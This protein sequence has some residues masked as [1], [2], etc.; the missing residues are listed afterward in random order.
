MLVGSSEKPVS[1]RATI[2]NEDGSTEEKLH[3]SFPKCY[4]LLDESRGQP[5]EV[6]LFCSIE[7]ALLNYE[8]ITPS[9]NVIQNVIQHVIQNAI[10]DVI[11]HVIQNVIQNVLKG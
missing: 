8:C 9:A 4:S 10:Q 2:Q 7:D 3:L 11:Q 5:I 1:K 6:V